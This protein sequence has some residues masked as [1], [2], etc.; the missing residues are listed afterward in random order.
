MEKGDDCSNNLFGLTVKQ[1]AGI[2]GG[3]I[4]GIVIA[5]VA[6]VV[7]LAIGGKK[8]YDYYKHFEDDSLKVEDNPLY[9]SEMTE[10]VNPLYEA[11]SDN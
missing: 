10:R 3:I 2:G 5:A 1:A 9:Q 7:G 11:V 8:G 6:T 4:A